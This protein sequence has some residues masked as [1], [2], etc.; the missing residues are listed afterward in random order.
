MPDSGVVIITHLTPEETEFLHSLS[1]LYGYTLTDWSIR[2]KFQSLKRREIFLLN[3]L[4]MESLNL[5]HDWALEP[6]LIGRFSEQEKKEAAGSGIAK[7]WDTQEH[8]IQDL[9]FKENFSATEISGHLFAIYSENSS[10]SRIAKSILKTFGIHSFITSNFRELKQTLQ[11]SKID[12]IILD[13]DAGNT[14]PAI[15]A[16]EL[17]EIRKLGKIFPPVI[18]I[19]DFNKPE[20]FKELSSG[21]QFFSAI[22]FSEKEVI[23]LLINSLPITRKV[24][25]RKKNFEKYLSWDITPDGKILSYNLLDSGNNLHTDPCQISQF[26]KIKTLFEW[27]F[28]SLE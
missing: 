24:V 11:E 19:K 23:K 12:F 27:L 17:L 16:K 21:I 1:K 20:L 15:I 5:V 6:L 18:G 28:Q 10:F 9:P 7:L 25:Q 13:W 14:E 2:E 26:L 3:E 8:S 22:L 4:S